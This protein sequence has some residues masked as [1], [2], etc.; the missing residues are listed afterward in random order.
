MNLDGELVLQLPSVRRFVVRVRDILRDELH[1]VL[2]FGHTLPTEVREAIAAECVANVLSTREV[3]A[4]DREPAEPIPDYLGR[5][6]DL[7]A[8]EFMPGGAP[9]SERSFPTSVFWLQGVEETGPAE[10]QEWLAF[11][12]KTAKLGNASSCRFFVPLRQAPVAS[13]ARLSIIHFWNELSQLEVRLLCREISDN[14]LGLAAQWR[15]AVIP[16]LAGGDLTLLPVLWNPVIA[17]A[18]SVLSAL[19]EVARSREWPSSFAA[20]VRD[21]RRLAREPTASACP[22][23]WRAL[24]AAGA[25]H[26]VREVGCEVS[27]VALAWSGSDDDRREVDHRIWRGQ[28]RYLLPRLDEVRLKICET[29]TQ[30]HG[31]SW[32]TRLHQFANPEEDER[33]RADPRSVAY[34]ALMHITRKRE[35]KA[36]RLRELAR[37]GRDLRNDLAHYSAVSFSLYEQ[38]VSLEAA[39]W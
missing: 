25:A 36:D 31:P 29:L 21:A 27:S 6:L 32:P 18:G 10:Q 16:E 34:G 30:R 33:A 12:T 14:D 35:A 7:P 17:G 5:V 37:V 11:V 9:S 23:S 38:F 26:G 2:L 4:T 8:S 20:S 13:D 1:V 22:D 15:E 19:Q 3:N 24:W 39:A 28:A